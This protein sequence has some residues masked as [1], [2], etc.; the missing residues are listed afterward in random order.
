M[1]NCLINP[2]ARIVFQGDSIT[3]AGRD[4]SATASLGDGYA[5]RVARA[6]ETL[7]PELNCTF[8][9]RGI[10][11][12]RVYDVEARWREDC[13]ALQPDVLSILIG[14]NDTWRRYDSGIL[15][16][17]EEFEA[18]YRRILDRVR[19]ETKAQVM[20]LE[21]FVIHV[22]SDRHQWREDLD[23]RIQAVRRVA[24]DYACRYVPLDGMFAKAAT[25]RP[26]EELAP[27]GVHPS[28]AGHAM[29]ARAWLEGAGLL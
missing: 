28:P 25:E 24:V 7:Y 17:S 18:S 26:A 11:G 8:Y 10:S 12:N 15:S 1:A 5:H 21:P 4:R 14:I 13:I 22:P 16:D 9:N 6:I 3:D 23:P 27:D 20:L 19:S 29:I 2:G